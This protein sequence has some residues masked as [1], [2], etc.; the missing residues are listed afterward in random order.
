M[1][2]TIAIVMLIQWYCHLKEVNH[3]SKGTAALKTP[4][5]LT[6]FTGCKNVYYPQLFVSVLIFMRS[7][8]GH[9]LFFNA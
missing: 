1:Y 3:C 9:S 4:F 5:N 2:H 8:P 6:S 7:C